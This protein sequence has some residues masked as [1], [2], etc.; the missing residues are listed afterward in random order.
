MNEKMLT[1]P[2]H[3]NGRQVI[4]K[5]VRDVTTMFVAE[6]LSV[7]DLVELTADGC[8]A[9]SGGKALGFVFAGSQFAP[10]IKYKQ[11][12]SVGICADFHGIEFEFEGEAEKGKQVAWNKTSKKMTTVMS[13]LNLNYVIGEIYKEGDKTWVMLVEMFK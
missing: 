7:G 5:T 11:G 8:K 12:D 2:K 9:F 13:N 3:Y 1:M 4:V 6:D 10:T